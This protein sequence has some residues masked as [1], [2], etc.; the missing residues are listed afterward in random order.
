MGSNT[1]LLIVTVV[2]IGMSTLGCGGQKSLPTD[3]VNK[4]LSSFVQEITSSTTVLHMQPNHRIQLP[5][6]I[7]NIGQET[8][9]SKGTLPVKVSYKWFDDGVQLPI[10]GERTVFPRPIAAGEAL[11]LEVAVLAPPHGDHL[12][13]KVTLVQEQ[14]AWF[15]DAGGT[16]LEIPVELN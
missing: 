10:E 13:L 1:K 2:T 8:W 15:T 9:A 16:P 7:R 5:V 11:P 12:V 14:V 3:E 4:P 6:A